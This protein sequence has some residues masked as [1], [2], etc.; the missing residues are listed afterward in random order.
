MLAGWPVPDRVWHAPKRMSDTNKPVSPFVAMIASI[1]VPGLG[2]WL[3]GERKRAIIA[4][5]GI[6]L[7]FVMG[8]L[9]AGIR[10]IS[11]PGYE[12]GYK[13]YVEWRMDPNRRIMSIA[14][15]QPAVAVMKTGKTTEN[16]W[17]ISAVQRL[18][19]D[20]KPYIVETDQPPIGPSE[21]VMLQ[22]PMAQLGDNIS[23]LGQMFNGPLCA[24]A[25]YLSNAA[26]RA[27]V[28]KSYTRLVDIG[29]LY[30]A[31]SGMLNLMLIVDAASRAGQASDAPEVGG[32]A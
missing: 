14:T 6:I 11:L 13:K 28:P 1:L 7:V 23:F 26:A 30:T 32:S 18:G 22:A 25:G 5:G 20:G 15:T 9:I 10:V 4:G 31:I 17:P 21:W 27:D 16:G 12:D 3:I 19:A 2:Y 29:A 8:I 24:V